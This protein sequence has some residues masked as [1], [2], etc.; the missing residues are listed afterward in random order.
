VRV[1]INQLVRIDWE[2][3][4][5]RLLPVISIVITRAITVIWNHFR[6]CTQLCHG[7]LSAETEARVKVNWICPEKPKSPVLVIQLLCNY[8]VISFHLSLF[9][10]V[11][12]QV[13]SWCVADLSCVC[14]C[15]LSCIV[16]TVLQCSRKYAATQKYKMSRFTLKNCNY[17]HVWQ[18]LWKLECSY[19]SAKL[20]TH[21]GLRA[22][23]LLTTFWHAF[24]K[25]KNMFLGNVKTYF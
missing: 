16:D 9:S 6:W 4:S 13:F 7:N 25:V 23:L 19:H 21:V 11:Q 18:W 8:H 3:N 17:T 14:I 15:W 12:L 2:C 1:Y 20:R 22:K 10:A 5:Y 24:K